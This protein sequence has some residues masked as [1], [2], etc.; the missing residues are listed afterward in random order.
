MANRRHF[1]Y[2]TESAVLPKGSH[3][4]EIWN[5]IRLNRKDLYRGLATRTEFE[6]GLGGNFQASLY[7]N[8]STESWGVGNMILSDEQFGFS[9]EGKYK[10][11]DAVSDP[12]GLALYGEVVY[13]NTETELEGKI[14]VDKYIDK[15]LFAF[16]AI[17][18]HSF[19]TGV[20]QNT[21]LI[22]TQTEEVMELNAG[23][24][25][26]ITGN[27]TA[28]LEV[29]EHIKRPPGLE[30]G[31]TYT[32]LFVG[33]SL[34]IAGSNWWAAVSVMPQIGGSSKD[35]GGTLSSDKL[36]LVEHE[37]FEARLLLSFEF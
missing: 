17:G 29:R 28:G 18:E 36:E 34:S 14:I 3:E 11:L 6:F 27:F 7:L 8:L 21:N 30:G 32:A 26:F 25:Y 24:T 31:G 33:P 19:V 9:T 4:L 16:N 20:N 2:T 37:K 5:T 35:G 22:E 13:S 1:T 23:A 15:L 12:I 10:L